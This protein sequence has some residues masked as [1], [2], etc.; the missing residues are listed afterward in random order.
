M[1]IQYRLSVGSSEYPGV[2]HIVAYAV[3]MIGVYVHWHCLSLSQY[4]N[5]RMLSVHY[6]DM[7]NRPV[8]EFARIFEFVGVDVPRSKRP[9]S[10]KEFCRSRSVDPNSGAP[11]LR[12]GGV[13]PLDLT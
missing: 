1:N 11:R 3:D 13:T 10:C 5:V 12:C 2:V 4:R 7:L 8:S 9:Q 6:E